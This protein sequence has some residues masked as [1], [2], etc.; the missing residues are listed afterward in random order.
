MINVRLPLAVGY[1]TLAE[2]GKQLPWLCLKAI[3]LPAPPSNTVEEPK[4][5]DLQVSL[6]VPLVKVKKSYVSRS[7]LARPMCHQF[8]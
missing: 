8:I 7:W 3:H 4:G 5:K 6:L 1:L 2:R